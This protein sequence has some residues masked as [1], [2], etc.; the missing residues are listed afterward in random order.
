MLSA[1]SVSKARDANG[2]EIEIDPDAFTDTVVRQVRWTYRYIS[3]LIF[4]TA[5]RSLLF[6]RL[7]LDPL[8][9]RVSFM[10]LVKIY[11]QTLDR[12]DLLGSRHETLLSNDSQA[13]LCIFVV[14]AWPYHVLNNC[15]IVAIYNTLG[16]DL[17]ATNIL[18]TAT[19]L[20]T[21]VSLPATLTQLES[22]ISCGAWQ[23]SRLKL[24][25]YCMSVAEV[26][27]WQDGLRW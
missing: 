9:L 17:P 23:G 5:R 16:K 4:F 19:S 7:F 25:R 10:R 22:I 8:K 11:I 2:V 1:F 18:C 15:I 12:L 21:L 27:T 3:A 14:D 24:Y 20:W 6:A 13:A 26:Y